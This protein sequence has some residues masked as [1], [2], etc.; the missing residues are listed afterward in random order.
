MKRSEKGKKAKKERAEKAIIAALISIVAFG[1]IMFV[2]LYFS[3]VDRAEQG[4]SQ[5]ASASANYSILTSK[6]SPSNFL[7][8]TDT[9]PPGYSDFFPFVNITENT[10]ITLEFEGN[11]PF[12]VYFVPSDSDYENFMNNTNYTTYPGCSSENMANATVSCAVSG[13]GIIVYNPNAFSVD[14]SVVG[15]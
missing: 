15:R 13:G 14:Y 8:I 10:S 11:Y 2:W 5:P 3:Y 1:T 9:L 12:D 4:T 7:N 6:N